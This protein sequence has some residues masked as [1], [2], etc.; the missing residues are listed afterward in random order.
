ACRPVD[1]H[2]EVVSFRDRTHPETLTQ[3]FEPGSFCRNMGQVYEIALE[4]PESSHEAEVPFDED[5]PAIEPDSNPEPDPA[6]APPVLTAQIIKMDVFWRPLPGTTYAESTQTNAAIRYVLRTGQEAISYEG[7]GFVYFELSRDGQSLEGKI[8]S[9][10]LRPMR[11]S[12]EDLDIFG[13]CRLT[14]TFT[15]TKDR[16]GVATT[17]QK[18]HRWLGPSAPPP[19]R[20]SAAIP[21]PD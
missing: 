2:F 18:I 3:R 16:R 8:E 15:A 9:S 17:I 21:T 6:P 19:P 13:P 4:L 14:G 7:A 20:R 12:A 5:N 10:T 1:T 11:Q